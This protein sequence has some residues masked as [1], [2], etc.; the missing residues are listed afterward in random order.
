V[1]LTTGAHKWNVP[2]GTS[3]SLAP[4]APAEWGS[5]NLGG[6]ITT[7]SGLVFIGAALDKALRAYDIETGRE[8]WK[9][10]LPAGARAT[11]MTYRTRED[12]R[13]YVV[14]AAGG[15]DIFGKGDAIVAFALP[16]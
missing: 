2:L 12:G 5:P 16:R 10:D 9:G 4:N 7:A 6:A 1:D 15:S 11:P 3:R 14:I 8:L 13:Q